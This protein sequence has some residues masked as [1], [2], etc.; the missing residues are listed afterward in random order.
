MAV[1][2]LFLVDRGGSV[3]GGGLLSVDAEAA[4]QEAVSRIGAQVD[5][6][7]LATVGALAAVVL[8][9]R[10]RADQ[11]GA[12]PREWRTVSG[13]EDVPPDSALRGATGGRP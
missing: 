8:L 5:L 9:R 7:V 11:Q 6:L 10:W 1:G 12:R 13:D 3:V 4:L 2:V